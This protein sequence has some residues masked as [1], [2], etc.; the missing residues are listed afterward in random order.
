MTTEEPAIPPLNLV[1][2]VA[3]HD[4]DGWPGVN[5]CRACDS[6][7]PC[8]PYRIA[9][10]AQEQAA[11]LM[12]VRAWRD[13]QVP[14]DH[15]LWR[16]GRWIEVSLDALD[17]ALDGAQWV[18]CMLVVNPKG[19]CTCHYHDSDPLS[20]PPD[21][22]YEPSCPV[23]SEHVYDPRTG[24]WVF[25]DHAKRAA[26]DADRAAVVDDDSWHGI[27]EQPPQGTLDRLA[28]GKAQRQQHHG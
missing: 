9:K 12:R 11:A 23:H 22:E 24:R 7:W 5:W 13:S 14:P 3:K 25:A 8:D 26:W 16:T 2:I 27:G 1:A 19:V 6:D 20:G 17:A 4:N 10:L 15:E 18:P 28:A 21:V